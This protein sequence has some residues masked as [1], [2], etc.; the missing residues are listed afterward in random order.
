[1]SNE[2]FAK[3]GMFT[4]ALIAYLLG[5]G[6]AGAIGMGATDDPELFGITAWIIGAAVFAGM[7]VYLKG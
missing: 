6:V 2:E 7:V 1:M 3:V 5:T 4:I